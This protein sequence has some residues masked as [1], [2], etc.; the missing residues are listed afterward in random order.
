[1]TTFT[2]IQVEAYD[3]EYGDDFVVHQIFF[4]DFAPE[5]GGQSWNFSRVLGDE[6]EGVCTVREIQ[7]TTFYDGISSFRLSADC[8]VCSFTEDGA[9]QAGTDGLTIMFKD[10]QP[11]MWRQVAAMAALVFTDRDYY[12]CDES[13]IV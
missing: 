3:T 12:S 2:A 8:I 1:M 5:E 11:A 13:G 4:E 10:I 7:Q 9:R 6:D